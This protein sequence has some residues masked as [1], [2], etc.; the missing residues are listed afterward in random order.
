MTGTDSTTALADE[1]IHLAPAAIRRDGGTQARVG[2]TEE[3]VEEYASAMRDGLWIWHDGNRLT[4]F[5]E[6]GAFWLAD[7]FHRVEAAQRAALMTVPC[8]VRAGTRRDAVLCAVG[9]NGSH[10]LRRNRQDVRRAIELLLRDEEWGKWSDREISRRVGCGHPLVATVRQELIASGIL[11][12]IDE[13]T[14]SRNGT[15]YTQAER[16]PAALDGVNR[17]ELEL[18]SQIAKIEGRMG[19]DG[20]TVPPA[21]TAGLDPVARF[22]A[23]VA[24][25]RLLGYELVL[26]N[27]D[28]VRFTKNGSPYGAENGLD[29]VEER[30]NKIAAT[31]MELADGQR[32]YAVQS[33]AAHRAAAT[34]LDEELRSASPRLLRLMGLAMGLA[35]REALWSLF[36]NGLELCDTR[37][38]QYALDLS[39]DEARAS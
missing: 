33:D 4:V 38:I 13:R 20:D 39:V 24:R 32:A 29:A 17:N 22:A 27:R 31:A 10:G 26:M 36:T 19:A 37:A 15:T 21:A 9:A 7:G 25:A 8:E 11:F 14:V 18:S 35:G 16:Q 30:L 5:A 1:T 3:V 2:N 23:L 12:Q 28:R 6:S 34:A